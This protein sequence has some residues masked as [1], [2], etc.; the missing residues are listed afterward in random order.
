MISTSKPVFASNPA[1]LQAT[2][3]IRSERA[4]DM[5][6]ACCFAI[7]LAAHVAL[8]LYTAHA[9]R[10][11]IAAAGS[12][13]SGAGIRVTLVAAPSAPPRAEA[14]PRPDTREPQPRR[15][16]KRVRRVLAVPNATRTHAVAPEPQPRLPAKPDPVPDKVTPAAPDTAPSALNPE[17][18]LPSASAVHD[19]AHVACRFEQ[20][21]YPGQDRRLGHEGAVTLRVTIDAQGRVAQADVDGSSGYPSLDTAARQALL[22]GRCEPYVEHGMPVSV[23]AIQ[24][25]TFSLDR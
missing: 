12:R 13:V 6:N 4:P 20:P 17:L 14:V 3:E 7:V 24:R 10:L 8:L 15:E 16:H 22:A 11:S 25:I 23:R 9:P 21:A 1:P 2:D 5:L 18:N 19:V